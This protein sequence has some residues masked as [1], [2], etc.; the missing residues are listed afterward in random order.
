MI[1]FILFLIIISILC[2]LFYMY[3]FKIN[4]TF[5]NAV[6][7]IGRK[8]PLRTIPLLVSR[9][10]EV[11][12]DVNNKFA[13]VIQGYNIDNIKVD[14]QDVFEVKSKEECINR[15]K[16]EP[17]YLDYQ[18]PVISE[19]YKKCMSEGK[20]CSKLAKYHN[21]TIDTKMGCNNYEFKKV[22]PTGKMF[23]KL[24]RRCPNRMDEILFDGSNFDGILENEYGY[25]RD[26]PI[27]PTIDTYD[28]PRCKKICEST[29][30]CKFWK[31][32]SRP[33]NKNIKVCATSE[34]PIQRTL[35]TGPV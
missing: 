31:L 9:Q 8:T 33:N 22:I 24:N 19:E 7:I 15:C 29:P 35:Y 18:C 30:A 1:G 6:A 16:A 25:M 5:D 10:P 4:I 21:N 11:P 17:V 27:L 3:Y 32:L 26:E 23:C 13:E 28:A 14:D 2:L 34:Y 12:M 20:D